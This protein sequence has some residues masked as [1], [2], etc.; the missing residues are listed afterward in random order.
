VHFSGNGGK[1]AARDV[2][3][4]LDEAMKALE[5]G[6]F[7]ANETNTGT[8]RAITQPSLGSGRVLI[9][10]SAGNNTADSHLRVYL[11]SDGVTF[12]FN[13]LWD[14]STWLKDSGSA[15]AGGLRICGNGIELL[16]DVSL[17]TFFTTWTRTLR[18]TSSGSAS[19]LFFEGTGNVSEAGRCGSRVRNSE[20]A[21]RTL[22]AGHG[23]TFRNRMPSAPSTISFTPISTSTPVPTVSADS[24]T[25]DGFCFSMSVDVPASSN[26]YWFGTYYVNA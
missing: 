15:P 5:L 26:A 12:V 20:T 17:R 6:H 19:T 21:A 11:G 8:H 22:N 14:G 23:V 7:R 25:A 18:L 3:N 16:S 2:E 24:I 10:D 1:L 9:W 4:A 13:A